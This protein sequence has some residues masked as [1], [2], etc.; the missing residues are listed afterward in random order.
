[1]DTPVVQTQLVATGLAFFRCPEPPSRRYPSCV[2]E[3]NEVR[4][5]SDEFDDEFGIG[6]EDGNRALFG[7]D[8]LRGLMDGIDDFIH[9]RQPRWRRFR[10]LGPVLLGSAMWIDDR[11]L[12]ERIGE[13]SAACII[14]TKPGTQAIR[15]SEVRAP[16]CAQRTNAWN[17]RPGLRRPQWARTESPWRASDRRAVH[18]DGRR[19]RTDD[20]DARL[21]AAWLPIADHSR[22]AGTTRTSVVARRGPAGPHRGCHRIRASPA[23]DILGKFHSLFAP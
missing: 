11:E 19:N 9:L 2:H 21:P 18:T 3:A 8:V 12:I 20:S 14:V 6:P 13:L 10:S 7:L 15:A 17:A 16:A 4:R 23:L 22:E 5:F 1:M